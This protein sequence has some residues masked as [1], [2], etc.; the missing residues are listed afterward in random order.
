M[1]MRFVG[2]VFAPK[3]PRHYRGRHRASLLLVGLRGLA[4]AAIS[5]D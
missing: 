5:G 4:A 2:A 1:L 3:F